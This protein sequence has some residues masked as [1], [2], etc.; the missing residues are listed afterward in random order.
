MAD[1]ASA[2]LGWEA[3]RQMVITKPNPVGTFSFCVLLKHLFGFCDDYTK[4]IWCE[5]FAA[6][7]SAIR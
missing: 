6:A 5:A 7:E 4:V 2:S 1:A 3:R